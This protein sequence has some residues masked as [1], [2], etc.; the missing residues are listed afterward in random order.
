M[1]CYSLW[2]KDSKFF[3]VSITTVINHNTQLLRI[4]KIV[5]FLITNYS[6][7]K[8]KF[9]WKWIFRRDGWDFLSPWINVFTDKYEVCK[10]E[11]GS[12]FNRNPTYFFLSKEVDG[13]KRRSNIVCCLL[14]WIPSMRSANNHTTIS[15]EK[16][17]LRT[18]QSA[19]NSIKS[20]CKTL[21]ATWP[22]S[23]EPFISQ[24][25]RNIPKNLCK[26]MAMDSISYSFT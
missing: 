2:P 19:D 7:W 15:H 6:T 16:L 18:N 11:A 23:L 12:C 8:V 13:S 5:K 25:L 22:C 17:Y 24:C 3:K 1:L 21:E 14:L 10:C 9:G 20:R 4:T 26:D